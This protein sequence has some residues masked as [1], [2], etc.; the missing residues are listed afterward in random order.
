MRIH[1][2]FRP[3]SAALN[4]PAT[5][6][7]R[8]EDSKSFGSML[9]ES[10]NEVNKYQLDADKAVEDLATGRNKNIH[11]T[12]IAISQADLA[13]RMTMQV[14]NKVVDAYQEIMRMSV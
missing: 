11:E 5:G 6:G 1:M 9:K 2:N 7:A 13:F 3:L 12:M 4:P 10:I 14:R 8:P